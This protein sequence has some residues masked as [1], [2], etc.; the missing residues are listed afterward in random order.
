MYVYSPGYAWIN[1]TCTYVCI[2]NIIFKKN[3]HIIRCSFVQKMDMRFG[4]WN[5]RSMYRAGSLKAVAEEI[6]KCKLDLVGVQEVRWYGGGTVPV[7]EYTFFY[8]KGNENHELGTGFFIHMRIVS[9]VKRLEF[10]SDR[11]SYI[12]LRGRWCNIIVLNV[13]AN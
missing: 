4:N 2:Y 10:V 5:V 13:H 6:S 7:G 9:A 11:M 8:G 1:L 3:V 12:I